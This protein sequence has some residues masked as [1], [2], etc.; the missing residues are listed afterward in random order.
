VKGYKTILVAVISFL[1]YALGW[2]QLVNYVDPKTIAL[3]G[4]VLMLALRFITS[5]PA[6]KG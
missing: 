3:L 5:S 4:S 6:F 2:D 1:V